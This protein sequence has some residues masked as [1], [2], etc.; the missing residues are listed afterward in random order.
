[1][2]PDENFNKNCQEIERCKLEEKVKDLTDD[3]KTHIFQTGMF[4]VL[5]GV[6]RLY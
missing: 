4:S 2:K 1:M 6:G 3:Q 5:N